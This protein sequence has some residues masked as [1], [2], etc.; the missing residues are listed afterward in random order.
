MEGPPTPK[1]T[2]K[3]EVLTRESPTIV[4]SCEENDVQ[5]KWHW[6]RLCCTS[7]NPETSGK[8]SSP[9]VKPRPYVPTRISTGN[10][11]HPNHTTTHHTNT[12]G[13]CTIQNP[14]TISALPTPNP[15]RKVEVLVRVPPTNVS[16]RPYDKFCFILPTRISMRRPPHPNHTHIHP[17]TPPFCIHFIFAVFLYISSFGDPVQEM[18]FHFPL[19]KRGGLPGFHER[20]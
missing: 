8:V 13:E 4:S 10:P 5:L 16:T 17:Q 20:I 14:D 12:M 3:S 9:P 1:A 19:W 7:W 18:H 2:R 11:T 6:P 15:T